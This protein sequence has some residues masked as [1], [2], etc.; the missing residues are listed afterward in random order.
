MKIAIMKGDMDLDRDVRETLLNHV[1]QLFKNRS[2]IAA[3]VENKIDAELDSYRQELEAEQK[4]GT[5]SASEEQRG[6]L[7]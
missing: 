6:K 2:E 4:A 5:L 3:T 1:E 7:G